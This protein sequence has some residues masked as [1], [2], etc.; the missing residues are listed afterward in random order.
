ME[1]FSIEGVHTEC[2]RGPFFAGWEKIFLSGE[3]L[4]IWVIFQKFDEKL[5]NATVSKKFHITANISQIISARAR[6]GKIR[7]AKI[8]RKAN[9]GVL[10]RTSD[11]IEFL[12]LSLH[13]RHAT[14]NFLSKD[15]GR[16]SGPLLK[17]NYIRGLW[18]K[19]SEAE[20]P[21]AREIC[22]L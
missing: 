14:L 20:I 17:I 15:F 8:S 5:L 1:E 19:V 3:A 7:Q 10:G 2:L 11:P 6:W 12:E 9:M 22:N 16:P 4:N 18:N 13:F 21:N